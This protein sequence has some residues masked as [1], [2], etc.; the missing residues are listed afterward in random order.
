VHD[1]GDYSQP[2]QEGIVITVEP[3]IY[4]ANESIGIRLEDDVLITKNGHKVLSDKL[5]KKL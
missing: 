5:I 3:G 4:I 1:V 2:L